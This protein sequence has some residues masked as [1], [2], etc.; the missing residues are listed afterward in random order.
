MK[1]GAIL[2]I[3]EKFFQAFHSKVYIAVLSHCYSS[4]FDFPAAVLIL[5]G[6][7]LQSRFNNK[8]HIQIKIKLC[9]KQRTDVKA[10]G[11]T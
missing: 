9:I 11:W 6:A 4:V 2:G 8:I 1:A 5:A 10:N 7:Y 3:S